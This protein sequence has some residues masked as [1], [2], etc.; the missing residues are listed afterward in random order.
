V[1]EV[2][3]EE[4]ISDIARALKKPSGSIHGMF[5]ATGGLAHLGGAGRGGLCA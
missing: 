1:G 5:K 4:T 3:A 2:E